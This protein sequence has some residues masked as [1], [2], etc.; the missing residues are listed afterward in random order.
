[1]DTAKLKDIVNVLVAPGKGILAADE[2]SK[3]IQKRFDEIGLQSTP[4]TNLAYRKMLFTALGIEE[5]I[6]GVILYDETIRQE[7]NGVSVPQYLQNKGIVPGI[8]VDKGAWRLSNFP[9]EKIT[10]GLDN[11]RDRLT[12][13]KQMGARFAKWRA[14][15][16]IEEGIPTD[17]CIESNAEALAQYAALCQEADLVPIIEPEVLMDGGHDLEKCREV[18]GK[19]LK[20]LFAKLVAHKVVLEGIILKPNMVISGED[21]LIQANSEEIA[22][23]TVQTFLEVVPK[24]VQG[25]VFLSGGQTPDEATENLAAI[26]RVGGPWQLSFSYGRALQDEALIVWA[27]KEENVKAAQEAF[28]ERAK[29]VSEAR[30]LKL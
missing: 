26:N 10:E 27:G 14:V 4:E 16:K 12:E 13:Y 2:S 29:K 20:I 1:M 19:T 23:V 7:I 24:E 28:L 6:S 5:Y 15:I 18:T 11:L 9:E 8:K 21:N 3:T 30:S 25:I 22:R 17:T